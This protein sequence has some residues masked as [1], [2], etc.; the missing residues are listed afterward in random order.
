[1]KPQ[2]HRAIEAMALHQPP[3]RLHHL[4]PTFRR[5]HEREGAVELQ[6][7][8]GAAS[9]KERTRRRWGWEPR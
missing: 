3:P 8:S 9:G 5:V 1:M 2:V 7:T 4:Q 6:G